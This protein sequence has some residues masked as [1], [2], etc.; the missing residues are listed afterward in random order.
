MS[1][2]QAFYLFFYF[3][4]SYFISFI[5]FLKFKN[6]SV[7]FINVVFIEVKGTY[8]YFDFLNECYVTGNLVL[9]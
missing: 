5:S 6:I 9:A 8:K 7:N 1:E 2:L 4:I 3:F